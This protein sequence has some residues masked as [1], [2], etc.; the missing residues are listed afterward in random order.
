[1]LPESIEMAS[2]PQPPN[3]RILIASTPRTG[4]TWVKLLLSEIYGLPIVDLPVPF[5][6]AFAETL[7]ERWIGHQH[8][9]PIPE[10]VDWA[11]QN[12]IVVVTT[13]R[14]PADTLVSLIHYI[15]NQF[16]APS[17][18][19]RTASMLALDGDEIGSHAVH[20][21]RTDFFTALDISIYWMLSHESLMVRYEDLWADT[22]GTLMTLTSRIHPISREKI[23]RAVGRCDL[24]ALRLRFDLEAKFFRS[25]RIGEGFQALPATILDILLSD[26]PYPSQFAI[27]GY[28]LDPPDR[29]HDGS[30]S[31]HRRTRPFG[32]RKDFDNGVPIPQIVAQFYISIENCFQRWPQPAS[33]DGAGRFFAWLNAPAEADPFGSS[34]P[35]ITNLAAYLYQM[36]VDVQKAF[37]DPFGKD[38]AAFAD[39]FVTYA[40]QEFNLPDAFLEPVHQS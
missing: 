2:E 26:E 13:V 7:G 30:V 14:H 12:Q 32:G 16:P 4:N 22:V 8:Y 23:E 31:A 38:R 37:P 10:L 15:R 40:G 29:V 21:V 20:Y 17:S 9:L 6:R 1:M 19:V 18:I 3:L 24:D 5:D 33:T 27:L 11:K 28:S 39:W 35:L 25:G 34:Q 36:R